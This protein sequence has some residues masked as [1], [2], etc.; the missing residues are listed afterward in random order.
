MKKYIRVADEKER[1]ARW[2][3]REGEQ[4]RFFDCDKGYREDPKEPY[5]DIAQVE[6]KCQA[7]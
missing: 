6:M 4:V 1:T 2:N 3:H 5:I 7:S